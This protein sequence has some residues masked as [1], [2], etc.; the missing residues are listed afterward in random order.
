[1]SQ[2][3]FKRRDL[4]RTSA[5]AGVGFMIGLSLDKTHIYAEGYKNEGSIGIWIRINLN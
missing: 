2:N 4:I 5:F 3:Y 1:M